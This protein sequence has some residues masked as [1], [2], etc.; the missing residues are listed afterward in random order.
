MELLHFCTTAL[1]KR[2]KQP[3][4]GPVRRPAARYG[5][6][7]CAIDRGKGTHSLSTLYRRGKYARLMSFNHHPLPCR[8]LSAVAR[9]WVVADLQTNGRFWGRA[10]SLRPA[11]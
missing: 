9:R 4:Q 7:R 1:A 6:A 8:Y 10:V 2:P 11:T 3:S 5:T